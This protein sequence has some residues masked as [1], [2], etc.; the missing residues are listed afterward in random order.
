MPQG[1]KH[2]PFNDL[3]AMTD[4]ITEK[5]C[6]IMVEAIQGEGGVNV[7]DGEYLKGIRSLCDD[8]GLLLILDEV[9]TGLGRTG[10]LFAHQHYAIEPDIMTLA[11][12]LGSGFPIGVMVGSSKVS[13]V[14]APGDHATTFGGAPLTST[15]AIT[16]LQV[17]E[18]EG[19]VENCARVGMYFQKRLQKLSAHNNIV[20]EIRG[21][22]LI[23][24]VELKES[25][26]RKVVAECLNRGL[27]INNIGE[28]ILR[29]L[30]PLIVG[31]D[32]IE[33]AVDIVERVLASL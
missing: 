2:V 5:T 30:P 21:K 19:L 11:K 12:G 31:E 20:A 15:V 6:A 33:K 4:A 26:A 24:G 17:L 10:K 13:S 14:F 25:L 16:T 1:F 7:A 8:N 3:E 9:Q 29:F 28:S 22:G 18:E 23:I 32:E 27:I